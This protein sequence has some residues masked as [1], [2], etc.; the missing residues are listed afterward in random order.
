M[1]VLIAEDDPVSRH[2]LAS[3]LTR[4]GQEVIA[5]ANGSAALATLLHPGGPRLAILD[6]MM[7]GADGLTVCRAVRQRETPYVYVILLTA[8][9]RRGNMETALDAEVDDFLTK[10]FDVLEL[11]AR[12]R[13]AERVLNL[14][15]GLLQ[16]QETLRQQATRDHLTG[17]WNRSMVLEQFAAELS[18]AARDGTPLSIAMADIDHFK[19]INDTY[20]HGAGDVVLQEAALRMRGTLRSADGMGRYGGD[21]FLLLLPGCDPAAAHDVADRARRAVAAE[22]AR[23]DAREVPITISLGIACTMNA[24]AEPD[25][26]IAAADDALY[27]AKDRGRNCVSA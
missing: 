15:E 6:W 5:V 9:E 22:P 16:A 8:Q 10:P 4:L 23:I 20:G 12:L 21:E 26:L 18:R 13:A 1:R 11:R 2:H 7:P 14:Q 3:T 25:A 19:A 27:R 17:F 24:T